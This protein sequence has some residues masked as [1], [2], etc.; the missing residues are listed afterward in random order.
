MHNL[1]MVLT[2]GIEG[3]FIITDPIGRALALTNNV[4]EFTNYNINQ[5]KF[6]LLYKTFRNQE[7]AF[8]LV[9]GENHVLINDNG[10]A[11][12]RQ[13]STSEISNINCNDENDHMYCFLLRFGAETMPITRS[14]RPTSCE[15]VVQRGNEFNDFFKKLHDNKFINNLTTSQDCMLRILY[16]NE[17][18]QDNGGLLKEFVANAVGQCV[19]NSDFFEADMDGKYRFREHILDHVRLGA[20]A[21]LIKIAWVYRIPLPVKFKPSVFMIFSG[22]YSSSFDI[23]E[24]E[25][26][27]A[28]KS[29][30]V[31]LE[32]DEETLKDLQ[33]PFASPN[34][35][36]FF[37]EYEY[38]QKRNLEAFKNYM[39]QNHNDFIERIFSLC[40][41]SYIGPTTWIELRDELTGKD[42]IDLEVVKSF[43]DDMRLKLFKYITAYDSVPLDLE[44]VQITIEGWVDRNKK[45]PFV[46][47]CGNIIFIWI[48][49]DDV[50]RLRNDLTIS[51]TEGSKSGFHLA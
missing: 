44:G 48:F 1:F 50:D 39:Y 6:K 12:S 37:T 31:I 14:K 11:K 33:L 41:P 13:L 7:G 5:A 46:Q 43:D 24:Q 4:Y 26:S 34:G 28:A 51:I 49:Y 19:K 2:E 3:S 45:I 17:M 35:E 8:L 16:E 20:F 23:L 29:I 36:R 10:N 9:S 40:F 18:G 15:I 22:N 30:N 21:Y 42:F 25:D 38:V 47:T 32:M 27:L